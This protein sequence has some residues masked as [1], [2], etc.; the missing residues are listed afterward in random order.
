MTKA[1]FMDLAFFERHLRDKG[2]LASSTIAVYVKSVE[3]FLIS[4]PDVDDVNDFNKFII[5]HSIKKRSLHYYSAVRA[6]IM[7]RVDNENKCNKMLKSLIKPKRRFDTIRKRRHLNSSKILTVIN[8]LDEEKHRVMAIIQSLTGVRAGDIFRLQENDVLP[9]VY[10]EKEVLRLN[11]LGKGRKRNVVYIFD[12]IAQQ[13]IMHYVL[14]RKGSYDDYVFL[15]VA[16]GIR[17]SRT[18]NRNDIFKLTKMNYQWYWA[19][20]KQALTTAGIDRDDFA[21]HDFRRCFARNA[22]EKYKDIHV[23][24]KLLHHEDPKTTLR[25][26]EQEGLQN[27][28]YLRELQK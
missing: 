28:D 20:L 5:E 16:Q 21:T 3:K 23:L 22:W 27:I 26:L 14:R 7:Y 10:E 24:Q 15:Q 17:G 18:E 13:L 1:D 6:F 12:K 4:N 11:I 9:E 8:Y 25:Y 2:D 19:D